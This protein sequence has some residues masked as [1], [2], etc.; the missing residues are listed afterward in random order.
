MKKY[1]VA[2]LLLGS[3]I[4]E[5]GQSYKKLLNKTA[6]RFNSVKAEFDSV[7]SLLDGEKTD[8][9]RLY[10]VVEYESKG[11]KKEFGGRLKAYFN[12]VDLDRCVLFDYRSRLLVHIDRLN[13]VV[14]K[15]SGRLRKA[16]NSIDDGVLLKEQMSLYIVKLELINQL[17][18]H[19]EE[20]FREVSS[21]DISNSLGARLLRGVVNVLVAGG[22]M[23][24]ISVIFSYFLNNPVFSKGGLLLNIA[25]GIPIAFAVWGCGIGINFAIASHA[26][27]SSFRGDYIFPL[28]VYFPSLRQ[29]S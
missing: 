15:S 2:L 9:S 22:T 21:I 17:I 20:Y 3:C 27:V 23:Y 12:G 8:F 14:A 26:I 1:I 24:L 11:R 18:V 7:V 13:M 19:S 10:S 16:L 4:S 25:Y 6:S 29:G 5:A 28:N